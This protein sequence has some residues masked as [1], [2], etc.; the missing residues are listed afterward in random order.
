MPES[1]IWETSGRLLG[2]GEGPEGPPRDEKGY[3]R[4]V[5][6]PP[7]ESVQDEPWSFEG[8]GG[9]QQEGAETEYHTPG[10]PRG[11]GGFNKEFIV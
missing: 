11:V 10:D 7:A 5:S 3:P 1:V 8:S 2:Q 6:P 4:F 9:G